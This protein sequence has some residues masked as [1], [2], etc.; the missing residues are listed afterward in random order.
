MPIE[1]GQE[2]GW[3]STTT[4]EIPLCSDDIALAQAVQAGV[5]VVRLASGDVARTLGV[6][7]TAPKL[8]TAWE[9]PVDVLRVS[10]DQASPI[11]AAAHIVIGRWTDRAGWCAVMNAAFIGAR[12]WAP[13]AHPGDGRADIVTSTVRGADRFKARK[14]ALT[15]AHVPHPDI[16]IRRGESATLEFASQ[17]AVW[18]DGQPRPRAKHIRFEVVPN[19]IVVA[20]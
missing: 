5:D 14:R 16:T 2:W 9:V 13:R 10:L 11:I 6:N 17:R 15:G 12:N 19:A 4:G 8:D 7:A 20:V 3:S 18:V 1:R